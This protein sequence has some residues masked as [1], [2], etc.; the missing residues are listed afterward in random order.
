MSRYYS[1]LNTVTDIIKNYDGGEPLSHYLKF[2][3][4]SNKKYGSKDRKQISHLCYC[5]YRLGKIL[6]ELPIEEKIVA[7]LFLCSDSSNELLANLK[8][9]WNEKVMLSVEEKCSMLSVQCSLQNLFPFANELSNGIDLDA[10]SKSFLIQPDLFLRIRPG[11]K[12]NVLEK[13]K[14]S[15]L[16]FEVIADDC[17]ALPNNSKVESIVELNK[18]VVVQDYSSQRVGEF[19]NNYKRKTINHKHS[20]WDCCAASGGKSILA[21]DILGD[22]DLTVSDIRQSILFN[23]KKRF[24]EAGIKNYHSFIA[25]LSVPD[26]QIS[27]ANCDLIV[28]DVPCTGS[29]TWSRTPEQL[30]F[31][32]RESI[33]QYSNLQ[34]KIISNIIPKIKPGGYLLYI[35]C[36][37]FKKEN[38]EVIEFIRQQFHLSLIQKELLI[39]YNKKADTMFAALFERLPV[40]V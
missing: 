31:F 28:A 25:D 4:S 38:E 13:L 16:K 7:A 2:L 17:I 22:I 3:F 6:K 40:T 29:G 34:K 10:F 5:Y 23:L 8:P 19:L 37:V 27:T 35:T 20:I 26:N 21:K 33:E 14:V 12:K 15:G 32:N 36:S 24:T 11:Y 30:Y 1:Y 18:E 9:E 39:G